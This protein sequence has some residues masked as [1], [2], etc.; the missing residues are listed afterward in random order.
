M[1][2]LG[3]KLVLAVVTF[4]LD[5]R[6]SLIHLE[7]IMHKPGYCNRFQWLATILQRGDG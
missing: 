4:L 7:G 2:W 6:S 1:R 5:I 3:P